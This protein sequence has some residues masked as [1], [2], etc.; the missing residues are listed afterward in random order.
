MSLLSV[1]S[2]PT[3]VSDGPITHPKESYRLRCHSVRS[4]NLKNEAVLARVG[5]LRLANENIE[6]ISRA[7]T[8]H[9]SSGLHLVTDV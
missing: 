1:L 7:V 5:L 4:R 9:S 3:E 8:I 2:V 6:G